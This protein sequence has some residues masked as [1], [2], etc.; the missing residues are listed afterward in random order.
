MGLLPFTLNHRQFAC[1]FFISKKA[2]IDVLINQDSVEITVDL[3]K[4]S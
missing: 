4:F 3:K 1:D 2:H